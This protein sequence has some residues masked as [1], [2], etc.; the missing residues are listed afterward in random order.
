MEIEERKWK[1]VKENQRQIAPDGLAEL[2]PLNVFILPSTEETSEYI[3]VSYSIGFYV[4]LS[5]DFKSPQ[6][7][8]R[9]YEYPQPITTSFVYASNDSFTF[10]I[11]FVY[12]EENDNNRVAY[13]VFDPNNED[14]FVDQNNKKVKFYTSPNDTVI[15]MEKVND[16]LVLASR[17]HLVIIN[18]KT[19][20]A[21]KQFNEDITAI[22]N[23]ESFIF[24]GFFNGKVKR[25]NIKNELLI[26]IFEY[27]FPIT[28]LSFTTESIYIGTIDGKIFRKIISLKAIPAEKNT[29]I[30]LDGS[31]LFAIFSNH[32]PKFPLV[33]LTRDCLNIF[34]LTYQS[35]SSTKLVL[36]NTLFAG[37]SFD[38]GAVVV[39]CGKELSL[40]R[41]V[42]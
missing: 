31:S 18:N 5:T 26:D 17:H 33:V 21:N 9:K 15:K 24:I 23:A 11:W 30:E 22:S 3:V 38:R 19:I 41:A 36:P 6:E 1:L 32:D 37:V 8:I 40:Y 20:V 13:I 16:I 10:E 28:S 7:P 25:Y 4:Y 12:K 2:I 14:L 34:D 29:I 35:V 39:V 27:R 42:I